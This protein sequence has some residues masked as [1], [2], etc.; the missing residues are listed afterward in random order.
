M[1]M[2][3][4]WLLSGILMISLLFTACLNFENS[5][6]VDTV[7]SGD[8]GESMKYTIKSGTLTISGTGDME[9]YYHFEDIPWY[10]YKDTIEKVIVESGVISID[11]WAFYGFTALKSAIIGDSVIKV[12]SQAFVDCSSLESVL[13]GDSTKSIGNAAFYNCKSL[14]NVHFGKS[15]ESFDE[16]AFQ[17]CDKLESFTVSEGNKTFMS[18]NGVLLSKDS[19]TLIK[20]A[21]AA[22]EYVVPGNVKTIKTDSFDDNIHLKSLIVPDSVM[23]IEDGAFGSK[24]IERIS[25]GNITDATKASGYA[26]GDDVYDVD[27]TTEISEDDPIGNSVFLR[28]GESYVKQQTYKITFTLS[29][30]ESVS[31]Q[32]Y[33]GEKITL[34][35]VLTK[36][37]LGMKCTPDLPETMPAENLTVTVTYKQS[38]SEGSESDNTTTIIIAGV[39]V[40]IVAGLAGFFIL[41]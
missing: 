37:G 20:Y 34:P 39:A 8:C 6:A 22:K 41:N 36:R 4:I 1:K 19:A 2:K 23:S 35:N 21:G 26:I 7:I 14:K 17:H 33:V 27:G 32:Y 10:P 12:P 16:D 30:D 9:V 28:V 18:L 15:V 3:K 5:E 40:V 29:E 25:I 13:I 38:S 31:F 11:G 24:Y